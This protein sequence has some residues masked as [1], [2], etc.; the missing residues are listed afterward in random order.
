MNR[1][2]QRARDA[3]NRLPKANAIVYSKANSL[4]MRQRNPC[5]PWSS[6]QPPLDQTQ[7]LR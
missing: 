6:E 3:L 1:S 5:L 4:G 2:L 7:S